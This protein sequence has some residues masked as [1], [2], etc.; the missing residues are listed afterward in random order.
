LDKSRL[1]TDLEVGTR[2]TRGERD[3]DAS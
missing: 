3:Y 1:A 2:G